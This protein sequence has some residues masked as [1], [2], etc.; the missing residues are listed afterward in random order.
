[1]DFLEFFV[2]P[3]SIVINA[4]F[5]DSGQVFPII[6]NTTSSR[7]QPSFSSQFFSIK[8]KLCYSWSLLQNVLPLSMVSYYNRLRSD[9]VL[10]SR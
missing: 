1:M 7:F 9:S 8:D 2:E 4:C 6:C 10:A 5:V 3:R